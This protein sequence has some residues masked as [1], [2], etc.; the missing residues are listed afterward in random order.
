MKHTFLIRSFLLSALLLGMA[1]CSREDPESETGSEAQ[2]TSTV[3]TVEQD[4]TAEGD[5]TPGRPRPR[6]PALPIRPRHARM[7]S[8]PL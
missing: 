6:S 5:A 1:A 8:L 2:P 4:P 7:R 3:I